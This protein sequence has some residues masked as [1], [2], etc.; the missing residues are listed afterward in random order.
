MR[1]FSRLFRILTA[2]LLASYS[3]ERLYSRHAGRE[4][5]KHSRVVGGRLTKD[6]RG[7]I[8]S[9][10]RYSYTH[11]DTRR[12]LRRWCTFAAIATQRRHRFILILR[13]PPGSRH[14]LRR[15]GD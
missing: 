15:E 12:I 8:R 10:G 9:P 3:V 4:E 5:E 6:F 7:K 14:L 13:L 11:I 2:K 1:F